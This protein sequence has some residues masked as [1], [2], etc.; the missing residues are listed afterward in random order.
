MNYFFSADH[1]FSH[2]NI[3]KCCNRPF[4][5]EQHDDD[6]I[7]RWNERVT[8]DDIVYYLGDFSWCPAEPILER[9][10]FK[11]MIWVLGNHDK[12][13]KTGIMTSKGRDIKVCR[14]MEEISVNGQEITLCHFAMRK[15]NKSHYGTWHL[16]GHSHGNLPP[17][18]LS[19]DVGVDAHNYFPV[20]F[21]EVKTFMNKQLATHNYN[22]LGLV[23]Q[24]AHFA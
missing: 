5:F 14:Y 6:L 7:K 16:Y 20:S 11:S 24:I 21:N 10:N 19:M 17:L 18:G 4:T 15:W 1:H 3:L 9:L 23:K 13:I 8:N 12:K 2:R 22:D